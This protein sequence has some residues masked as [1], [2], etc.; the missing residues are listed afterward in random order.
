M[1]HTIDKLIRHHADRIAGLVVIK[2]E[3]SLLTVTEERVIDD[4]TIPAGEV[5]LEIPEDKMLVRGW[6]PRGTLKPH[7]S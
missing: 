2:S 4:R 1:V 3:Q 6:G 5:K 7:L